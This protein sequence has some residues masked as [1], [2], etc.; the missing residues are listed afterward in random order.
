[1]GRNRTIVKG[2]KELKWCGQLQRMTFK[3]N[4]GPGGRKKRKS[5]KKLEG[6][7][8]KKTSGMI[9][10]NKDWVSEDVEEHYRTDR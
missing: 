6:R 3:T 9:V 8:W 5:R 2:V 7:D 1:M 4:I 10:L